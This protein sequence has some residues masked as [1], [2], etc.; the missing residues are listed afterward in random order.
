MRFIAPLMEILSRGKEE[1]LIP[2][3]DPHKGGT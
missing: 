1:N 2:E 3:F